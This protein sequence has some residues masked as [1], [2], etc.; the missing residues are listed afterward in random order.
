MPTK[1]Q[2]EKPGRKM[3]AYHVFSVV[4]SLRVLMKFSAI[5]AIVLRPMEEHIFEIEI[6]RVSYVLSRCPAKI[7]GNAET[8]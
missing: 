3:F 7:S 6:W 1:N 8:L 2:A 4:H 5:A